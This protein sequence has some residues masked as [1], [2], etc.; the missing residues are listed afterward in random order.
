MEIYF[1]GIFWAPMFQGLANKNKLHVYVSPM[2]RCLQ[3]ADS[4]MKQLKYKGTVHTTIFESPGLCHK[5]DRAF[6]ANTLEPLVLKNKLQEAMKLRAAHTWTD[7]GLSKNE[8]LRKFPWVAGFVGFPDDPAQSWHCEALGYKGWE[9]EATTLKRAHDAANFVKDLS[10][11]LPEGDTIIFV[12]HG[13]YL[14]ELINALLGTHG[15]THSLNNTS[16]SSFKVEEDGNVVMEF[17]NRVPHATMDRQIQLYE[18]MGI[19]EKKSKGGKGYVDI[20]KMMRPQR[21][22]GQSPY[23]LLLSKL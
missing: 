18:S 5:T 9:G 4:L 14:G 3:T 22:A 15:L 11:K 2:Q 6:I 7:C 16:V 13:D 8:I 17:I 12:S 10:K 21:G 23:N 19:K 20:G 1:L